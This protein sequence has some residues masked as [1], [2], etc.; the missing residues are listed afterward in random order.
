L[1]E[2]SPALQASDRIEYGDIRE[3]RWQAFYAENSPIHQAKNIDVPMLFSHGAN[4]PRDPVT[5][6]DRMVR[7][8]RS[9]G[10]EVRYL[11]FP[12]EGHQIRKIGN[13]VAYHSAVA[14]F[15]TQNLAAPANASPK[16]SPE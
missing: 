4:D 5:E 16:S 15:L 13:R 6:S 2:A 8:V 9:H 7:E 11:R 10:V 12:D 14:E 1:Q 3:E